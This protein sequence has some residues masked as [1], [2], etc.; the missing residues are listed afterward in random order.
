MPSTQARTCD[1]ANGL[2][3][4]GNFPV[5]FSMDC[6]FAVTTRTSRRQWRRGRLPCYRKS[7]AIIKQRTPLHLWPAAAWCFAA[8][9]VPGRPAAG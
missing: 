3:A 6:A 9:G 2:H 8:H 4:A 1:V 7:T 5:I